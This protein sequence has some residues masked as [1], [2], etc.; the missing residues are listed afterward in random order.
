MELFSLMY[1]F[2]LRDA[3]SHAISQTLWTPAQN[4]E[5]IMWVE[6]MY[7]I[8]IWNLTLSLPTLKHKA[9]HSM[10]GERR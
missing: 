3:Q 7:S 4:M 6:S 1:A 8:N 10:E 2:F 5:L 9:L